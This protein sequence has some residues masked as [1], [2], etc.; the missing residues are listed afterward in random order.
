MSVSAC[1]AF[2]IGMQREKPSAPES[3]AQRASDEGSTTEASAK[4]VHSAWLTKPPP[5]GFSAH[6]SVAAKTLRGSRE[7]SWKAI[8]RGVRTEPVIEST[9]PAEEVFGTGKWSRTKNS[10]LGTAPSSSRDKSK[11]LISPP[12]ALT[13][14]RPA[15]A[16]TTKVRRAS[17]RRPPSPE[18]FECHL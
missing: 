6:S 13:F 7:T 10:S 12:R 5:T 11:L 14:R 2:S 17:R 16:D 4:P 9:Q 3:R 15:K 18:H 1:S 8:L